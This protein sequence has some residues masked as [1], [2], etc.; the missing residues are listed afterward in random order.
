M[1]PATVND[2]FV[3]ADLE[4]QIALSFKKQSSRE[5]KTADR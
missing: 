1:R 3:P 2:A 5:I 4:A